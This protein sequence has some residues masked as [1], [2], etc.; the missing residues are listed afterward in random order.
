ME[1]KRL[2]GFLEERLVQHD[3][4]RKEVQVQIDNLCARTEKDADTLE[5][6][7]SS[8]IREPFN[9]TEEATFNVIE[10]L[11]NKLGN[12]KEGKDMDALVEE[13]R[14]YLSEQR[15]EL[16]YS[17]NESNFVDSYTLTVSLAPTTG[18][19]LGITEEE[20]DESKI[21]H[22]ISLLQETLDK[23][24]ES[25]TAAQD[26]LM[27]ICSKRREEGKEAKERI[28]AK[29]EELFSKEDARIQEIVDELRKK[30]DSENPDEVR[31]AAARAKTALIT[32]QKYSLRNTSTAGCSLDDYD[33]ISTE[34]ISLECFEFEK[35]KPTDFRPSFT[36][37]GDVLLSFT[38]FDE[39]ENNFLKPFN[40]PFRVVLEIWEKGHEDAAET[41]VEEWIVGDT[42]PFCFGSIIVSGT[43]YCMKM[44]VECGGMSS[45]W[46]ENGEITT[47]EFKDWCGWKRF[48]SKS[49]REK[50]SVDES[51]TRAT[52]NANNCNEWVIV[53]NATLSPNKVVSWRVKILKSAKGDCEGI[54]VGVAP[55]TIDQD[56][57]CVYNNCGWYFEPCS[58]VLCSGPPHKYSFPG[59]SYGPWKLLRKTVRV[60]DSIGVV[61]D[62]T[63]GV[64]SYSVNKKSYGVAY[65]GIPLD[66]PLV[67]C[68]I[69]KHDGDSVEIHAAGERENATSSSIPVPSN[70]T[71]K[72]ITWDSIT[73]TW[74]VA[75]GVSFYQIEVDGRKF[76]HSSKTNA[77]IKR[78]LLPE[79]EHTFRIRSLKG[80]S[81][82]EW[83]D[84]AKGRTQKEGFES[85]GWKEC[86]PSVE[87]LRR[88]A[89]HEMNSKVAIKSNAG[90]YLSMVIG[91]TLIPLNKVTSWS[92]KI[93]ESKYNNGDSIYV[94]VVPS[95][96][97]QNKYRN[98]KE[99]GWHFDCCY[100]ALW[101]GP[102]H[103]YWNKKYGQKKEDGEYVH[104]GD[105]VGV[106]MDTAKGELSFVVNRVNLGVAFEGIPLDK[107]LVPCVILCHEGDS[108]ELDTSE[109]KEN[110]DSSISIPSNITAKNATSVLISLAWD[111][112]EGASFYQVEVDGGK[113]LG[114]STNTFAKPRFLPDTEHSFRV[115]SVRGD[116]V[117]E[118][119][120]AVKGR[121]RK[122]PE[123]VENSWK[124][125]PANV[126]YDKVYCLNEDNPRIA[127]KIGKYDCTTI[128]STPLPLNKVTSWSIKVLE[129]IYND[130]CGIYIGVAP[131]DIDQD[132]GDNYYKCGWYFDCWDSTLYSGPPHNYRRKEYGPRKGKGEY[133][134]TGDSVGVVMDTAKGELSFV[135]NGV[136][137]GVAYEG[138][139]L[140]KPIVPCVL[141]GERCDSVELV[142]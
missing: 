15:Y 20:D 134:H 32:R 133:V 74:D 81:V 117:S 55:F 120:D 2:L 27:E 16:Q 46:S 53:G 10:E 113:F 82:S 71:T 112:V 101:S 6:K 11:N 104:T 34:E 83:S 106:V 29:L 60:G 99:C 96:I 50:Y 139:P 42:K 63:F 118:W 78:G 61:M 18:G 108:V 70:I 90:S 67:P 17:E 3:N 100:S 14:K 84:A 128:G 116:S 115:R 41:H 102:P 30:M 141:L 111:A 31:E 76:L 8:E 86:S 91:S 1:L 110:V 39:S 7:I 107:P 109:V 40:L 44:K 89:I 25:M 131:S 52:A 138:I 37:D 62:T 38:F 45:G 79:T 121:T 132:G 137:L 68:V 9:T 142:I 135:V 57:F 36:K 65:E 59:K 47:P 119:S 92:I 4:S 22:I 77:F 28:N 72:S 33:I 124:E 95:D 51:N 127:S 21:E 12:P 56:G 35:R 122:T 140:D 54:Y 125:C 58:S 126:Y 23:N 129:S 69:L 136:D 98:Y 94:G 5:G 66:K 43:A 26:R 13:A 24:N 49:G 19:D 130:G 73:L 64:L 114:V 80:N 85:A 103:N 75:E 48:S 93:L 88:Y 97:D 105:S 87:V 123:Y